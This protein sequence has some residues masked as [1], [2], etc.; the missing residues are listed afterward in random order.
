MNSPLLLLAQTSLSAGNFVGDF[1][2]NQRFVLAIIAI[3]CV[4]LITL[5]LGGVIAGV[6]SSLREKQVEADLKHD[7]LDRGMTA[8]EIQQVIEATPRSGLDRWMGNWCKKG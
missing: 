3:G 5:I 2:N 6:W 8:E 1:S 4:S 7:M